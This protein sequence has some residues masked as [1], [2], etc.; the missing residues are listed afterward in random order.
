MSGDTLGELFPHLFVVPQPVLPCLTNRGR[1]HEAVEVHGLI[2]GNSY[3]PPTM[4]VRT[5]CGIQQ[6]GPVEP[7]RRGDG[8]PDCQRCFRGKSES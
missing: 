4:Y 1:I 3:S 5:R 2:V 8:F 6:L 7:Y